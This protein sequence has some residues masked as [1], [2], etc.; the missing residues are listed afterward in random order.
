MPVLHPWMVLLVE[1]VKQVEIFWQ[2]S[3]RV[4][5]RQF[6]GRGFLKKSL[7]ASWFAK[8]NEDNNNR[9]R[10]EDMLIGAIMVK[11]VKQTNVEAD[12]L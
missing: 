12:Q 11:T 3:T 10:E 4:R 1:A 7:A 5:T 2:D 6:D 8:V 9:I